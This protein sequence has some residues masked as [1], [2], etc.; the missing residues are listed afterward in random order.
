V[1]KIVKL[2]RDEATRKGLELTLDI[3]DV[4][5][6]S[7]MLD[8][9]KIEDIFTNLIE[10]AVKFTDHGF[11]HVQLIEDGKDIV[12]N[13]INFSLVVEDSGIGISEENQKKI[14]EIFETSEGRGKTT[15]AGLGLSI[16]KK[17][18]KEMNGDIFLESA[19]DKGTKFIFSISSVEVVLPN[20]HSENSNTDMIDFSLIKPEGGVLLVVDESS[21]VRNV[22]RDSFFATAFK[23]ISFDNPRDAIETLKNRD[24]DMIFIDIDTLV[25][26]DNA[27]SKILKGLSN[28]P[29]VTLTDKRIQDVDLQSSASQIAGHLKK[30]L[31]KSELF[32]ISLDVLNRK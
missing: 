32:K 25:S 1:Q 4:L 22:I 3:D 29:I 10:N 18:A 12:K 8:K 13:S 7:L 17:I 16:N 2:Q 11:V 9:E 23:V 20:A 14:F 6:D 19:L 15:G 26:D 30:P 31:A 27:V 5:P 24:V 21:E 28:A